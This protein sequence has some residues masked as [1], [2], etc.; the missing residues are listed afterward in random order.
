MYRKFVFL[1]HFVM[2]ILCSSVLGQDAVPEFGS[3]TMEEMLMTRCPFDSTAPAMI[4]FDRGEAKMFSSGN[5][6]YTRH[7]RIKFFNKL[8]INEW[9]SRSFLIEKGEQSIPKVKAV[10]LNLL[11]GVIVETPLRD[12]NIFKTKFDKYHRK[13]IFT[14]PN[15]VGG[16][17]VDIEYSSIVHYSIPS[18]TF[19]HSIPTLLSQYELQ[20]PPF[21][22]LTTEV[23]G[24]LPITHQ[25][26]EKTGDRWIMKNVPAFKEAPFIST[27]ED[28]LSA[29]RFYPERSFFDWKRVTAGLIDR[30]DFGQLIYQSNFLLDKAKELTSQHTSDLDKVKA[31][32]DYVKNAVSWNEIPDKFGETKL[33]EVIEKK[34]GSSGD[35][36]IIMMSMLLQSGVSVAPVLISNR[37]NGLP[38]PY[39]PS[40]WQFNDVIGL[41]EIDKK[42]YLIDATDKY[43]HFLTLP[44]RCMNAAGLVLGKDST[45][46]LPI[47]S[48]KSRTLTTAKLSLDEKGLKGQITIVTDGHDA[49][50]RRDKFVSLGEPEYWKEMYESQNLELTNQVIQNLNSP[51]EN[52][53]EN[54]EVMISNNVAVFNDLIYIEPIVIGRIIENPFRENTRSYPVDFESTSDI[55]Y[56]A[57]IKIPD[58]YKV[59]ELPKPVNLTLRENA[60]RLLYSASVNGNLLNVNFQISINKRV[61]DIMEYPFLR[62]FYAQIVSKQNEQIVLKR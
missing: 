16:S 18:W 27:Q 53:S 36:N 13:V 60:A 9:A 52:L 2:L 7:M 57:Q 62:E 35:I 47:T 30:E 38:K 31:V 50:E 37:A 25:K 61:F 32:M 21:L 15:V 29:I 42:K 40:L 23:Q 26:I 8:A 22:N 3:V 4:L 51:N 44:K 20:L 39:Y 33:K 10:T 12:E 24:I 34:T 49:A 17:I 48:R 11:N 14:M 41:I 59:E 55:Y 6:K 1:A 45:Y 54:L 46:W 56:V 5:A 28:F 19:Q 58:G 43:L